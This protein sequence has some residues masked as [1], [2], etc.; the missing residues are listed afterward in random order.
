VANRLL[1][2]ERKK[3]VV[4]WDGC[5]QNRRLHP[6]WLLALQPKRRSTPPA[7][8]RSRVGCGPRDTTSVLFPNFPRGTES[9]R[10][11]LTSEAWLLEKRW[12]GRGREKSADR[13]SVC[14]GILLISFSVQYQSTSIS[15]PHMKNT[16]PKSTL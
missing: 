2:K 8:L 6:S 11:A 9:C 15:R 5:D 7:S 4:G 16:T 10:S 13:W 12:C 14:W 3:N 1:E